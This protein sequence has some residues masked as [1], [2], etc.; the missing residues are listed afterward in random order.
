MSDGKFVDKAPV[1]DLVD[2]EAG[3]LDR[4]LLA[5]DRERA[6][7]I[8]RPRRRRR[9]DDPERAVAEFQRCD[10]RVLGLDLCQRRDGAGMNADDIAEKPF[11]HVDVM[12]GLVGE[13]AAVIGP[14][15]APG[16]LI[17]IG[18]VAAPAHAHRAENQAAEA[19]G[20]QRLARLHHRNVEAILLDDEQ[21]DAGLVAGADHVVGVL[22]PQRHRLLDDDVLSGLRAGDDMGGMH[23]A[24]RQHRHRVDILPGEKV[25]DVVDARERRTSTRS[26]RRA[27]ERCRKRR[28]AWL[29]RYDCRP[30]DPSD[31]WRYARI[32]AGQ[33]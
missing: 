1:P 25:V 10:R 32:R 15:A 12:A 6:F 26:R 7:E 23:S 27:R 17:V 31:A 5:E 2:G 14:G 3:D 22:Q 8:G 4:A 9:L 19:A 28:R 18:L 33:I 20:L 30:E 29:R 21:L 24:R 16:V 13:H 11:Q